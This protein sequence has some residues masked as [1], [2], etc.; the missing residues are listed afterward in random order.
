MLLVPW[1]EGDDPYS[2]S[3]LSTNFVLIDQHDHTSGKGRRIPTAGLQDS[4]V[5][6]IKIAP[7]NVTRTNIDFAAVGPDELAD[8]SVTRSKLADDAVGSNELD[9][10]AV[11]ARHLDP[12]VLPIGSIIP[13]WRP[14]T[15]H[16]VPTGWVPCDG[17]TLGPGAHDF[18]GGGSIVVPDLSDERALRGGNDTQIGTRSGSNSVDLTHS[19]TSPGHTHVVN[20]HTHVVLSHAHA[21]STDGDHEHGFMGTDGSGPYVLTPQALGTRGS[22]TSVGSTFQALY[23]PGYNTGNNTTA[24]LDMENRGAH[25]H[26]GATG[27]VSVGTTGATPGTSSVAVTTNSSLST[28]D[29]RGAS[30]RVLFLVKVKNT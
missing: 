17:R 1:D 22:A 18:E 23:L 30:M 3:Q 16:P 4:A 7:R 9:D 8:D 20:D 5:T 24:F 13:W 12:N 15:A 25:D 19:H 27:A 2:Y 29:V 14:G 21:L 11:H 26:G 28:T 6:S 10:G